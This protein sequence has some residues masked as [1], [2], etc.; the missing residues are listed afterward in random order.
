MKAMNFTKKIVDLNEVRK[1]CGRRLSRRDKCLYPKPNSARVRRAKQLPMEGRIPHAAIPHASAIPHARH[2]GGG[3][4]QLRADPRQ[5][6][7]AGRERAK[8]PVDTDP[9]LPLFTGLPGR[10]LLGKVLA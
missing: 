4:D 7:R 5:E 10:C 6:G 9:F 3:E 1:R 2:E 8:G